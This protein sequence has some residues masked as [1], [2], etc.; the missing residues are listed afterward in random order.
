[1]TYNV[2]GG[3]LNLAQSMHL[4]SFSPLDL[5]TTPALHGWPPS[6]C[7]A[8]STGW[9]SLPD[10]LRAQQDYVPFKQGLKTWLFSRH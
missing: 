10:D 8:R 1:M 3:T 9:N 5:A 6:I 4:F 2:F 7:C